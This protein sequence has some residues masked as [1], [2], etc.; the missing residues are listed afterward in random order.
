MIAI[1]SIKTQHFSHNEKLYRKGNLT[2][3]MLIHSGDKPFSCS[4]CAKTFKHQSSLRKHE[5]TH[6]KEKR[7]HCSIC[8]KGFRSK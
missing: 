6:K 7:F 8:G 5:F 1:C 4:V 3:H 2:K